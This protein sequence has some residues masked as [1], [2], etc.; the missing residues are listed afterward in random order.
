MGKYFFG[1]TSADTDFHAWGPNRGAQY[2]FG[3]DKQVIRL[4]GA[5]GIV[6]STDKKGWPSDFLQSIG[7]FSSDFGN[8]DTLFLMNRQDGETT[9]ALKNKH[10][11]Q[12]KSTTF[13]GIPELYVNAYALHKNDEPIVGTND[14]YVDTHIKDGLF[15]YNDYKNYENVKYQGENVKGIACPGTTRR[16]FINN[17]HIRCV[18][19][20]TEL[21]NFSSIKDQYSNSPKRQDI[22][23]KALKSFCKIEANAGKSIDDKRKCID[24]INDNEKR[25]YCFKEN[26]M[27]NDSVCSKSSLGDS[28]EI[29]AKEYC[30]NNP[31]KEFCACYNVM[32]PGLCDQLPDIPGCKTVKPIWDKITSSL[33]EGDTAQFEGMQPC[34]ASVCAGTAYQPTSWDANCNRDISICKADFDIGGDLVGSNISLKQD[35]GKEGSN[36]K[37]TTE[38][39]NNDEEEKSL[40]EKVFK[41]E[42]DKDKKL[43]EKR[44]TKIFGT[45]SSVSSCFM[46][47]TALVLFT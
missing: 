17:T 28:Y 41:L 13:Y 30:E 5:D 31:E 38:N 34:Y 47:M 46:C 33:D 10:A 36:G 26:R 7:S 9:V 8:R 37:T 6:H 44:S 1:R 35:C 18:Y 2:K 39:N 3:N 32:Q 16:G 25:N 22:Y 4:D 12:M 19:N 27:S 29:L 24:V 23:E 14:G 20:D 15:D 42:E 21:R 40:I 11:S 43:T 45:V